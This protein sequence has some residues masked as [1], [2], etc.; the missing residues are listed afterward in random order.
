M[1]VND[2]IRADA[3]CLRKRNFRIRPGRFYHTLRIF[4]HVT[5]GALHHVAHTVNEPYLCLHVPA[6]MHGG[7]FLRNEFRLRGRNGFSSRTLRQF[8]LCPFLF[9]LIFH[10][11]KHTDIHEAFNKRGFAGTHRSYHPYVDFPTA[12]FLYVLVQVIFFIHHQ[13]HKKIPFHT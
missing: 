2:L 10:K 12:S 3:C 13:V 5:G 1:V 4:F 9:M 8:V 11:G 7:S 6:K